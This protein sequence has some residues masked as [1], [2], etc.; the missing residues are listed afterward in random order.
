M[1]VLAL[2]ASSSRKGVQASEYRNDSLALALP[3]DGSAEVLGSVL[4]RLGCVARTGAPV[5]SSQR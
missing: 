1:D 5:R 2:T 3:G 4:A